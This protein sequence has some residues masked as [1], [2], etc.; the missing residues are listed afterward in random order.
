MSHHPPFFLIAGQIDSI[1]Q[2]ITRLFQFLDEIKDFLLRLEE[3]GYHRSSV[4]ST[5]VKGPAMV[6][7]LEKHSR[8]IV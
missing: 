2:V 5:Y 7:L 1:D 4:S 3:S 6:A 8:L